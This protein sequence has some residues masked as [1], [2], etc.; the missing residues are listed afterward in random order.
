MCLLHSAV[1]QAQL[2]KVQPKGRIAAKASLSLGQNLPEREFQVPF[3]LGGQASM[4]KV[5]FLSE[6]ALL[7]AR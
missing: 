6:V 2:H 5:R 4:L 7:A 1:T 3:L